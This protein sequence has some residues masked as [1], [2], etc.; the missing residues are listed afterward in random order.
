MCFPRGDD[1]S[2][3]AP[4][5]GGGQQ[6]STKDPAPYK[7]AS[8]DNQLSASGDGWMDAF[9]DNNELTATNP[10]A[11]SPSV[12]TSNDLLDGTD[13][14]VSNEPSSTNQENPTESSTTNIEQSSESSVPSAQNPGESTAA[15]A[16]NP[17][18]STIASAEGIDP[19]LDLNLDTPIG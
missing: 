15:S 8:L 5:S 2:F 16:Q 13:S 6:G 18:G 7:F 10:Q 4:V 17:S 11:S 12:L 1:G 3:L 9:N 14:E 19:M